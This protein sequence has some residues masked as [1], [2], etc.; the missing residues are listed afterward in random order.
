M[1]DSPT[2]PGG[3]Y[4]FVIIGA[5]AAGEAA[6]HEALRLGASVAILERELVGG[7]C[8]YWACM[9]SK[10]LLHGARI[11]AL[12]GD[13]PW[14]RASDFRDW[15]IN[16]E[17]SDWPSDASHVSSLEQAGAQVVRGQATITGPGTV[18]V[19]GPDGQS[20]Q[21]I[22]GR[23]LI[24]AVGSHSTLPR[25]LP[26]VEDLVAWTNRQGTTARELPAS[27]LIL[28][29][30][31][32]GVELAQ[33][34]ARFGIP[35]TL[36]HPRDRLNHRDHPR[37]S[38]VLHRALAKDGV[39]IRLGVGVERLVPGCDGAPHVAQ[40]SGGASATGHEVLF[41]I[42]RTVPLE[43]LGLES[44]GVTIDGGRLA[45]DDQLRIAE[46]TYVV[47]DPAGP[48][49]HTHVAHYQGEIAVRIALG[50]DVKP[51]YAAIPRAI[52]TEPEVAGVGLLLEQ[53]LEEGIDAFEEWADLETSAKGYVTESF[54]HA[55]IVVD[56]SSGRLVGAFI[57]GP[58]ASEA[59]HEAVLA[60]KTGVPIEVL[61][62]TIHAFPTTARV[63]GSVFVKAARRLKEPHVDPA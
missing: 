63:L 12:G 8:P 39:D 23:S 56:R 37:N 59:I 13:Y 36:V 46:N 40:L 61:A 42:G 30:G 9:P 16:R 57:G 53:A 25:D 38:A 29:G 14:S 22:R 20:E 7:S 17:R 34:Y 41:A 44:L 60:I 51:D 52:Y 28:G 62:D 21:V 26:G 18:H 58:G 33:V 10:A 55:T 32:T 31:P 1:H 2:G 43:G 11:H 27:L 5:G 19:V 6:A 54:G 49:M 48:E 45:P 50:E 47:G 35:V 15:M 3:S 4:D 24:I